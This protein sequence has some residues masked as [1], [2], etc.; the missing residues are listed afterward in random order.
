MKQTE[1]AKFLAGIKTFFPN[2]VITAAVTQGWHVMLEDISYE[3][4]QANLFQH[5]KI[6]RFP[7]TIADIRS[8]E[9]KPIDK[10][11]ESRNREIA[12][13]EWVR[14]GNEP[15]EFVYDDGS[16]DVKRLTS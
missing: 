4:A 3:Q 12:F 8:D 11:I 6:N 16:P 2:F 5:I 1:T 14:L 9:D 13:S 10:E 15:E 7:P